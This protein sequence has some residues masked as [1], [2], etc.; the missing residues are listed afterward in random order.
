MEDVEAS[1]FKRGWSGH[2]T[3][4]YLHVRYVSSDGTA[5]RG[6]WAG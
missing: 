6:G 2:G 3:E 5:K 1:E 4:E